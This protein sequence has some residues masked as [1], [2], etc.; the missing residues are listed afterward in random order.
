MRRGSWIFLAAILSLAAC[1]GGS[2]KH[3]DVDAAGGDLHVAPGSPAVGAGVRGD[4]YGTFLDIY[5]IDIA[6]DFDGTG[7]PVGPAWDIG[8]YEH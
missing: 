8:A 6:V 5:G 4:V 3:G 7:R 1:G 2:K